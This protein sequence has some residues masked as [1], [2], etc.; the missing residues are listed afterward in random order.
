MV[1]N[2]PHIKKQS[3]KEIDIY[4]DKLIAW[5]PGMSNETV[6]DYTYIIYKLLLKAVQKKKYYKYALVLGVLESAKI[7]F[8]RK[9]I[10]KYEDKKIKENG[11][12]E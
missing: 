11:D 8:Y 3:R 4:L 7:E 9:Q 1:I 2:I 12:V 5:M 6:G 10:A